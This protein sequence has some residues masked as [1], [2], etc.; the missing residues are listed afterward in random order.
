MDAPI[1]RY[2]QKV[3][4]KRRKPFEAEYA[5]LGELGLRCMMSTGPSEDATTPTPALA[6]L[7]VTG[8]EGGLCTDVAIWSTRQPLSWHSLGPRDMPL[9]AKR[10]R[11]VAV[12]IPEV[13]VS[14]GIAVR[15]RQQ[16]PQP[17]QPDV[18]YHQTLVGWRGR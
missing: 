7:L 14:C 12:A 5:L 9:V 10:F 2:T 3:R 16:S 6:D 1:R 15:P 18:A 13:R 11:R 17:Q 8:S 4:P